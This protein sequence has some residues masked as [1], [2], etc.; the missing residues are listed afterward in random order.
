MPSVKYAV[1]RIGG[2]QLKVKDGEEIKVTAPE[3]SE[4]EVLLKVNDDKVEIGEPVLA[5]KAKLEMLGVEKGKKIDI[6][7]FKAKSRYSKHTGFRAV[8]RKFKVVS[9]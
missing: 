4:V 8:L 2:R 1:I 7:R 9:F 6:F 3:Q 5:T